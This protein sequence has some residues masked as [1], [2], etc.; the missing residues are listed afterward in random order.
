MLL[1][2]WCVQTHE[3]KCPLALLAQLLSAGVFVKSVFVNLKHLITNCSVVSCSLLAS[4]SGVSMCVCNVTAQTKAQTDRCL[5][6]FPPIRF[7][8]EKLIVEIR[9][10]M[11]GLSSITGVMCLKVF[12]L[13]IKN[14]NVCSN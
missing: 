10:K 14:V 6:H 8:S 9:L 5:V 2:K 13:N 12:L 1:F 4:V 7:H 11:C 3:D